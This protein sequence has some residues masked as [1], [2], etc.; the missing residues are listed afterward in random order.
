MNK[1]TTNN[2]LTHFGTLNTSFMH[3]SGEQ[4]SNYLVEILGAKAGET[5][6]EI[7]VGTGATLVKMAERYSEIQLYGIDASEEMLNAAQKRINFCGLSERVSLQTSGVTLPFPSLFFDH[8]YIESVLAIQEGENLEKLL[9][10]ISRVLKEGGR[11][12]VNE[13]IWLP[14]TSEKEIAYINDF[15]K[16]HFGIIQANALYKYP[17]QWGKLLEQYEMPVLSLIP[18][19]EAIFSTSKKKWSKLNVLSRLFTNWGKLQRFISPSLKKAHSQYLKSEAEISNRPQC[20]QGF[21][22]VAQK[23]DRNLFGV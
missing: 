7:G 12:L 4:A 8:I 2:I 16:T 20:M 6:L 23:Q 14:T 11:L 13:T 9:S 18:V 10:E 15:C 1:S 5:V 19:E 21:F 17:E 22:F 3:A